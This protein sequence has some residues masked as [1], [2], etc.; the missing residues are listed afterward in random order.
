M[1][2]EIRQNKLLDEIKR[3]IFQGF[4]R[5]AITSR[6]IDGLNRVQG[7]ARQLMEHAL[8]K[9]ITR[10]LDFTKLANLKLKV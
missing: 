1:K 9:Q 2:L 8:Q 4:A 3:K 5:Q 6:G 7:L 10:V